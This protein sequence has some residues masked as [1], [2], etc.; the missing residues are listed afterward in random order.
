MSGAGRAVA[1]CVW[2]ALAAAVLTLGGCASTPQASFER[3]TEAK[4]FITHP[5][6][7]AVYVYRDDFP[8]SDSADS[9]LYAD[10][11]LIG[12]TLPG[13]YFRLDVRPGVRLLQGMGY[14][15]GRLKVET[16]SGE[17]HFVSLNVIVG[18][19]H[20]TVVSPETGKRAIRACC[21]LLENWAPGQRPLFR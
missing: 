7:A 20:F 8:S 10:N 19:S 17:L 15:Q 2:A 6:T 9:V 3:D 18:R 21:A 11:R 4:Q 13:T 14:D 1:R 12:A 5:G 16:R